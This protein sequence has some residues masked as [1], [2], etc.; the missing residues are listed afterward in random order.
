MAIP[1]FMMPVVVGSSIFRFKSFAK[2]RCTEV[3]EKLLLE[4]F[5]KR[6][7]ADMFSEI[8]KIFRSETL[9]MV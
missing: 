5:K 9:V 6:V 8:G 2:E 3:S 4:L 1:I 7:L